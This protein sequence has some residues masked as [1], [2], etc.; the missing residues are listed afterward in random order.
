MLLLVLTPVHCWG[1]LTL[2]GERDGLKACG[3]PTLKGHTNKPSEGPS[4]AACQGPGT[5]TRPFKSY[6]ELLGNTCQTAAREQAVFLLTGSLCWSHKALNDPGDA[7]AEVLAHRHLLHCPGLTFQRTVLKQ[8]TCYHLCWRPAEIQTNKINICLKQVSENMHAR[9]VIFMPAWVIRIQKKDEMFYPQPQYNVINFS[10]LFKAHALYSSA[11][12]SV[13]HHPLFFF[14][15]TLWIWML[16][17]IQKALLCLDCH[18]SWE[19]W[20]VRGCAEAVSLLYISSIS[21]QED[22]GAVAILIV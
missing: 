11:S 12:L 22:L 4:D 13:A 20:F 16:S 19:I 21:K 5:S 9:K 14:F 15:F 2:V 3:V 7:E 10:F 17:L 1:N 8:K 18:L 6:P